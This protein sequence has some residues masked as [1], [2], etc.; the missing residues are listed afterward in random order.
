MLFM[1]D[2][3]TN[4]KNSRPIKFLRDLYTNNKGAIHDI[5][6]QGISAINPMAGKIGGELLQRYGG[7]L[8]S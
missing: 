6:V 4:L 7:K 1:D 2:W 8:R 3:F 5:L